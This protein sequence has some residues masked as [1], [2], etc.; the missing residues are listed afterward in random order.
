MNEWDVHVSGRNRG[1]ERFMPVGDGDDEVR[2]EVVESGRQ[3]DHPDAGRLRHGQGLLALENHV[4]LSR[5][6]EAIALD[7]VDD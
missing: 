3:L 7:L 4:H 5:N 2:F 6:L 1:G